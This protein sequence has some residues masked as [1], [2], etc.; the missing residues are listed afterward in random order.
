M[1]ALPGAAG[2]LTELPRPRSRGRA[3]SGR[4]ADADTAPL[5]ELARRGALVTAP[6]VY[7]K[8]PKH[9]D[10][11]LLQRLPRR[12]LRGDRRHVARRARRPHRGS[13]AVLPS[14]RWGVIG[15]ETARQFAKRGL[16][17]PVVSK[18]AKIADLV[19]ALRSR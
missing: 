19:K 4:A 2:L 11:E 10:P 8:R 3:S 5:A 13:L 17:Y 9:L 1:A 6:I 7:E 15:P 16:P 18:H 14:V 12:G